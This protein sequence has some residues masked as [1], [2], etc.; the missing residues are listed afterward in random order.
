MDTTSLSDEQDQPTREGTLLIPGGPGHVTL[1]IHLPP[2]HKDIE[3][4]N[5]MLRGGGWYC[6]FRLESMTSEGVL[7][8]FDSAV[9]EPALLEIITPMAATF[10]SDVSDIQALIGTVAVPILDLNRYW[11]PI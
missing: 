9:T 5:I 2:G 6:L 10:R 1:Y 7:L 3:D 4:F 8:T 11:K